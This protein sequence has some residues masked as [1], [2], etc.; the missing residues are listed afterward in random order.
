MG[1]IK[2]Y[3][4][5]SSSGSE[6]SKWTI[7]K[8]ILSLSF[9]GTAITLILGLVSVFALY[10]INNY[11]NALVNVNLAEL[12]IATDMENQV[13]QI[14]Y[15]LALYSSTQDEELWEDT[16]RSL[17]EL[18]VRADSG[19]V[20]AETYELEVMGQRIDD[21]DQ[22]IAVYEESS[23]AWHTSLGEMVSFRSYTED[24]ALDF[25]DSMDEYLVAARENLQDNTDVGEIQVAQEQILVADQI[26]ID[27]NASM[28]DLW[29]AEA[30]HD[31]EA[32]AAIESHFGALRGDLGDLLNGIESFEDQ[33]VL[34]IALAT[35]NDNVGNVQAMI[36]ARQDVSAQEEV[37]LSAHEA[38]LENA[39][40]LAGVASEAASDQGQQ[41]NSTVA[42]YA[43]IIGIGVIIAVIGALLMGVI[44]GQSINNVLKN[45]IDRLS[46]GAEQV[47]AS[48]TQ[49]SGSSQSL[50]ESA[51]QQAASLQET[52]SSLEEISSQTKQTTENAGEAERAMKETEPRVAS[53]VEAMKRMNEAMEEIKK[54][55]LET[56]KIIKTIDDIAFQTNLLALNA[57]VEAARAGE[58]GKGFAVVAEEVRNLAQR[59][60][61]A[62]RN[63]SELIEGS[64]ESSDRGASVAE[65]V[66]ENLKK[67]EESVTSVNTL[68]VEIAAAANEQQ[69]GIEQMSSVMHEMDK[70]V[71]GNASSSEESASAAEELSSQAQEFIHV[72][73]NLVA[74]VGGRNKNGNQNNGSNGGY[75]IQEID[76]NSDKTR[77]LNASNDYS[78]PAKEKKDKKKYD[79]NDSFKKEA[80]ELIPLDD[81]D[82][83]DF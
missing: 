10:T 76:G 63:T 38:I 41:T 36:A 52:T 61:E 73:N 35:L 19:R 50:A 66:S 18:R 71:Q 58:A 14:G 82:F 4:D 46:G 49:L 59:S 32:L 8:R 27:F 43:W 68:V 29:R 12:S 37:R 39:T 83:S 31:V 16:K 79:S 65:E 26:M 30:L 64:Q 42:F 69:T 5:G 44:I 22:A 11:S 56:S 21:I 47:N 40:V 78:Q 77:S 57:A 80:H 20:L 24:S 25:V 1:F 45:I 54:S 51:S 9:G 34:S 55:S 3:F 28:K 33:A 60:A 81:D 70:V 74:L 2:K 62:A 75:S 17:E 13:R 7:R 72:V 67:I 6:N 53:G 48:S 15:N 23:N